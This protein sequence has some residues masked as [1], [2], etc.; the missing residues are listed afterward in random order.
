MR[1][2]VEPDPSEP[3][4]VINVRGVGYRFSG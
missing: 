2:K 3:I 4:H 1:Q